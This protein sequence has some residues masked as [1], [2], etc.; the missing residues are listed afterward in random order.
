MLGGTMVYARMTLRLRRIALALAPLIGGA[1]VVAYLMR[2]PLIAPALD[3]I[4]LT[5]D[6][7]VL[8]AHAPAVMAAAAQGIFSQYNW[9]LFWIAVVLTLLMRTHNFVTRRRCAC[10]GCSFCWAARSCSRCSC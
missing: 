7:R 2:W 8:L 5:A 3:S 1:V 4:G 10:S 6:T 9:H